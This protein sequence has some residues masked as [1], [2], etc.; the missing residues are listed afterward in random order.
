M[1]EAK[2]GET[3]RL[4]TRTAVGYGSGDFALN[5]Y[6]G[7][8]S[9]FLLYWYTDV[10]GLP[11]AVAGF[12]FFVGT[13]WDAISDPTVGF[14]AGRNRS[15]WG[16]YRPFL[17]IGAIPLA[18]SFALLLWVPPLEGTALVIA[19]LATHLLFRT[20]YT[21]V[22]VPYSALSARI[23]H[24]SEDRTSLAGARMIAA[25]TGSLLISAAGFPIVHFLGG[26]DERSGFFY[27][28]LLAGTVAVLTTW[29][30]FFSTSEPAEDQAESG[31]VEKRYQL[32]DVLM[33]VRTNTAF[34]YLLAMI[35]LFSGA[36]AV[37]QKSLVYYVK[38]GLEAHEQQHVVLFTH[39]LAVLAATPLWAWFARRWGRR[40]AWIY[41]TAMISAGAV[42]MFVFEPGSVAGFLLLLV[43]MSLSFAAMGVLFWSMLPDTIEYGQWRNGYRAEAVFF[44]F[45]A[46]VQKL[47]I[48]AIA[49][50]MGWVLAS[51]GFEPSVEQSELT[52]TTIKAGMTL[53]PAGFLL[54]CLV[55]L[56]RYPLNAKLHRR[57]RE[58]LFGANGRA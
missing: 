58:S 17:L 37:M 54:L 41:S 30:C 57:I 9:F 52:V 23:S 34:L 38:Y 15:R 4:T 28:A 48:G 24:R 55:V 10:V 36:A 11:P 8:L 16:R 13:F 53:V 50:L 6:W 21:V 22:S 2:Q 33:I 43:P 47:S 29:T 32:K 19:L 46:F 27:L 12:V 45:A 49:W 39:G 56:S 26:G 14:L 42:A 20:A 5:L 7:S 31:A 18:I 3:N 51:V 1:S 40:A 44:G 35:P 25:T